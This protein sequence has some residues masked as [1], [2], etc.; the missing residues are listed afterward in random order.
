LTYIEEL[1]E[2]IGYSQDNGLD[3]WDIFE[4][5][6]EA[7]DVLDGACKEEPDDYQVAHLMSMFEDNDIF[8]ETPVK[9][10][11]RCIKKLKRQLKK[12]S[13]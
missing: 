1:I 9:E 8:I 12:A 2:A 5:A 13:S 3:W 7:E 4:S 6:E 11:E 10:Y